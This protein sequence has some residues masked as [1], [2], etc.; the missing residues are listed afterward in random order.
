MVVRINQRFPKVGI[1]ATGSA[2]TQAV[3]ICHFFVQSGKSRRSY[4]S[5]ACG[6]GC[7]RLCGFRISTAVKI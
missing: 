3:L 1:A 6:N 5:R 2:L 4:C 7:Q